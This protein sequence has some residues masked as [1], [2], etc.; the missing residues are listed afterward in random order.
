[1]KIHC[2]PLGPVQANCYVV[3]DEASKEAAV[4]DPGEYTSELKSL[5]ESE[6]IAK[7][8]YILLTHGHYDHILGVHDLKED[9]PDAEIAIHPYDSA[10]LVCEDISFA[11]QIEKGFQKYIGYDVLAEDGCIFEL[12]NIKL[13][14][15]HTPGHTLGGVC[16]VEENERVM[17]TGDTL[18]CR[19]VGRTDLPGGDWETL[20]ESLKKIVDLDGDYTVYTG[21]N[22]STTLAVERE[23]NRYLRKLFKQN[24]EGLND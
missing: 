1:M 10:C 7:L 23:K 14:V 15:I 6:E 13:K 19:T 11:N 4:I 17:F 2:L 21:H 20:V 18:F 12:G 5:I 9:F 16:Y 3:V 8:K 22:R 24:A